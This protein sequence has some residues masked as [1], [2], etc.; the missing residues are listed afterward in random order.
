M[1]KKKSGQEHM[2]K[3]LGQLVSKAAIAQLG[4]QIEE[5]VKY[6]VKHLGEQLS[7]EQAS[8]LQTLFARV[9]TIERIL[10]EKHGYTAEDLAEKVSTLEDEKEGALKVSGPA[11]LNDIVRLEI[12]TKMTEQKEFQGSSRLK[13]TSTG[14]GQTL[15][16]ELENALLGMSQGEVKEIVFGKDGLMTAQL[17]VNRVSRL[18]NAPKVSEAPQGELN[19]NPPQG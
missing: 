19:E 16:E 10:M 1:G 18:V 17:T 2:Q 14:T 12:K 6:Y 7:N 11:E 4:P 8:T 9:V 15:G 13:V 5:V 3:S